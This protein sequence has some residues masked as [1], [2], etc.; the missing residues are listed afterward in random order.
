MTKV[1]L[2]DVP[3]VEQRMPATSW[4]PFPRVHP[5]PLLEGQGWEVPTGF[6]DHGTS[7]A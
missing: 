7:L 6:L 5:L 1:T 3:I 2:R 4:L